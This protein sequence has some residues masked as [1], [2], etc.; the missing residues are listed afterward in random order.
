MN[1]AGR[2]KAATVSLLLSK[3][4]DLKI[5]NLNRK[6]VFDLAPTDEVTNALNRKFL[7]MSNVLQ[8]VLINFF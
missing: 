5:R 8:L 3:G 6:T 7:S 1:A 2:N 4:A